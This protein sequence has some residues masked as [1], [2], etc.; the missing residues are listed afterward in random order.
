MNHATRSC[1]SLRRL[2]WRDFTIRRTINGVVSGL[3]L[4]AGIWWVTRPMPN[5]V[6]PAVTPPE[7]TYAPVVIAGGLVWSVVAGLLL[8]R[9][10]LLVKKIL[11]HGVAIK[12]TVELVDTYDTN[13]KSDTSMNRFTPTYAHYVTIA[14]AVHGIGDKVRIKL[15]HSPSSYGM[16][17]GGEVELFVLPAM[18][19]KPLIRELYLG[20]VG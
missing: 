10:Y 9:R 12:G 17:K 19:D 20:S 5:V 15:P 3:I 13:M 14:Y 8:L 6:P 16:K 18:S 1:P 7:I 4:A 2:Y 11:C